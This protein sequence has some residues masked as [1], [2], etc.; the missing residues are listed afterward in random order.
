MF[1][2]PESNVLTRLSRCRY[3][4]L[5]IGDSKRKTPFL[6]DDPHPSWDGLEFVFREGEDHNR[7]KGE[8]HKSRRGHF[9]HVAVAV[10]ALTCLHCL[11][12]RC[13]LQGSS[14]HDWWVTVRHC[15]RGTILFRSGFAGES[16]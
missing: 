13:N 4:K 9:A 11:A 12:S 7:N 10:T 14:S 15:S 16:I 1:S 2:V 6:E 3:V 5:V 8:H